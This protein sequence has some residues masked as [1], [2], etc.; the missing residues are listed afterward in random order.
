MKDFKLK[1]E[2]KIMKKKNLNLR[3]SFQWFIKFHFF[4]RSQWCT[5]DDYIWVGKRKI[6]KFIWNFWI[7]K[8]KKKND[9]H[10]DD[11]HNKWVEFFYAVEINV[12]NI[13]YERKIQSKLRF[14]KNQSNKERKKNEQN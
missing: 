3:G 8:K 14:N 12:K 2:T 13:K 10:S 4:W 6:P 11:E 9:L 7:S 5:T 1:S